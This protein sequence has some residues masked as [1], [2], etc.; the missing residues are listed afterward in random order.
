MRTRLWVASCDLPILVLDGAFVLGESVCAYY[1]I[2]PT[3][4]KA[5]KACLRHRRVGRTAHLRERRDPP[6]HVFKARD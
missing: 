5:R 1:A 4:D 6:P 2:E 3:K